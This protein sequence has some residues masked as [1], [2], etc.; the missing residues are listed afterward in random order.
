MYWIKKITFMIILAE[1]SGFSLNPSG[2]VDC[3][4][5]YTIHLTKLIYYVE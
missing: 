5:I 4:I 1:S 3:Y 2:L